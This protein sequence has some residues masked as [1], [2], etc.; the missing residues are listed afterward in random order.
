MKDVHKSLGV[1]IKSD[2]ILKKIYSICE[3]KNLTD[4]QIKKQK[5]TEKEIFEKYAYLAEDE[6]N[7]KSNKNVYA[8]NDVMTTVVKCWRGEKREAKEK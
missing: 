6:L 7:T 3:T 1:K 4:K 2:L 8:K 5:M